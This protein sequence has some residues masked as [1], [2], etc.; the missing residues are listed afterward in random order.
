MSEYHEKRSNACKNELKMLHKDIYSAL[1][2]VFDEWDKARLEGWIHK[3]IA[4]ALYQTWKYFDEHER[5]REHDK[6]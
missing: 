3:P 1:D 4:Y 5:S 2:R 6:S